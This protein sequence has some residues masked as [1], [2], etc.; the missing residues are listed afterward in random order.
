MLRNNLITPCEGLDIELI[1][2]GISCQCYLSK[3]G[4]FIVDDFDEPIMIVI[5]RTLIINGLIELSKTNFSNLYI[6]RF[7]FIKIGHQTIQY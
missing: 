2:G 3:E 5:L 1:G 4:R 7:Y 6:E